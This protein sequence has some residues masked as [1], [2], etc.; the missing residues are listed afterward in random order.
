MAMTGSL[1]YIRSSPG[2]FE[3]AGV[4][5]KHIDTE[6][7]LQATIVLIDHIQ[8]ALAHASRVLMKG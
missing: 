7:D 6:E 4:Q 3:L 5:K 8:R 2:S 1:A